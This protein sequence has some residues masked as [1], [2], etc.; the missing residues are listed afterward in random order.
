MTT[1][2]AQERARLCDLFDQVGPDAATLCEGWSTRDLAAHLVLRESRPDAAAGIVMPVLAGYTKRVQDE[3]AMTPWPA[4]VERVRSGPP[5]WSPTRIDAVE[6]LVNTVEFFVH[7]EDVR[8]AAPSWTPR[9]L[10]DELRRDLGES[11]QRS[12]RLLVRRAPTGVVLEPTDDGGRITAHRGEPPVTV[13]GPIGELVLFTNG[14]GGHADVDFD[15]PAAAVG[16]L[17]TC[18][19]GL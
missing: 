18:R 10:D 15:G 9:V 17:R 16:S 14:R 11:L 1:P 6:R 4:L 2:A 13:R 5:A 7:L 3:I 12:A 8:R 19:L